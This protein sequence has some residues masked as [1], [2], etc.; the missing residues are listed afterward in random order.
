MTQSAY[1]FVC[2]R[3][4][5]RLCVCVHQCC[6]DVTH[7]L[8][9]DSAVHVQVMLMRRRGYGGDAEGHIHLVCFP[10]PCLQHCN[11]IELWGSSSRSRRICL[12][13]K[14]R[15]AKQCFLCQNQRKT[16]E[17]SKISADVRCCILKPQ[18]PL[19]TE[20]LVYQNAYGAR[21]KHDYAHQ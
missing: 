9:A 19:I 4:R 8:D 17:G 5:G 6:S 14:K 3:G 21:R 1:V 13:S 18:Q 2:E 15:A 16:L 10:P 12:G 7:F 11:V 20:H